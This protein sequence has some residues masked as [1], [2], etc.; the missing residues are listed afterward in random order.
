MTL[1]EILK[2]DKVIKNLVKTGFLTLSFTLLT[3][4]C[5]K[6][7]SLKEKTALKIN[8][9]LITIGDFSKLLAKELK[10]NEIELVK[11]R[12]IVEKS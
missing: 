1:K 11:D 2:S 12:L 7:E 8:N 3:T 5:Q 9:E 4:S 6:S 10:D